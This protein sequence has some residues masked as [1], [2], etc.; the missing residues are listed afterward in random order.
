[1]NNAINTWWNREFRTDAD[2]GH[3]ETNGDMVKS[4]VKTIVVG[5][6]AGTIISQCEGHFEGNQKPNIPLSREVIS[7]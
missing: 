2:F 3:T 7:K 1:M 5:L 6:I 4:G